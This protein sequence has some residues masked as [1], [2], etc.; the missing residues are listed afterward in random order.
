MGVYRVVA[1]AG[2]VLAVMGCA[3]HHPTVG[4]TENGGV[5]VP[6]RQ[7]VRP[8][9][10]SLTFPGRPVDMALSPDGRRLYVKDNRGIVVIDAAA[11]KVAQELG[12][13][14][15]QGGS[16]HGIAVSADG[17]TVYATTAQDRLC[18]ARVG[19]DGR[20]A[21]TRPVPLPGP[22]GEGLSHATG[23]ALSRD[24]ARAYVC[25]SRNNA[26]AVV[27]L[28]RGEKTAEI[29]VGVAPYDVALSP[30]GRQAWVSNWGGRQ[31]EPGEPTAHSSGTPVV[32]DPRGVAASGTVSLVDLEAGR[33]TAQIEV[34]LHPSD[35]VLSPDGRAL[36]VANANSDTVSVLD[37]AAGAVVGTLN[38]RPEAEL[39]FGSQPNA[40]ALAPDGS[41]LYVANAG[42]NAVAVLGLGAA[43]PAFQGLIPAGWY[44][45]AVVSSGSYLYTASVKGY[46][47]RRRDPLKQGWQVYSH[48]GVVSRVAVPSPQT[49]QAYTAQA[50]RGARVK[51]V[52]A[53]RRAPNPQ[54]RPRPVP[55]R[56]G[57]PS[58]F[59]HVVYIVKENRTYDQ[60][61]GDL[62]QGNGDPELCVFGRRITP[63]HHALAEQFVLL[64]NF[65][66]N[67]VNSADGH[68]WATE[69]NVTDHLEKSFGGF[70]RS[71]TWGDD[72]LTYSASGF[73]W[74]NVLAHGKTFLNFGE[75]DYTE[76]VPA[77]ASFTDILYD[78]RSGRRAIQ[79]THKI[80]IENLARHTHPDALGWNMNIPDVLRADIFVQDL[81]EWE[82]KGD[83]PDFLMLFLPQD[84]GSGTKPGVP[85]HRAHM[86]DNDLALGRVVEAITKSRFWPE[87]CIFVIEDDPQD[88]FD[89]VDGHRSL[90]LVISPYTR[91]GAVVSEFYNQTSV[92]HT[93][94]RILGL[95]PMNQMDAMAPLMEACFQ[96]KPDLTPYAALPANI[97]LDELNPPLSALRGEALHWARKSLE[98]DLEG[99][100]RV[101][102]DTMN[103]IIWH[104]AKG[105]DKPYPA[106][107]AG[108]HGTGLKALGLRLAREGEAE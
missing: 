8:A 34:G 28:A 90:C 27:D 40:L 89:H 63:N 70:T 102:D 6:T 97:P 95:P 18:V 58:V 51:E 35:L 33:E 48:L 59:K 2:A 42:N 85:T 73:I 68:S 17:Q 12:F 101:D 30:D 4:S 65:Y 11:W 64:D 79:F 21:W 96:R 26:L 92:L 23:I 24:G 53:A 74:D 44:P 38:A 55:R 108:A 9:G 57:E 3:V 75:M 20:L 66:C 103:R 84:H 106:H 86:A 45:G 31:A 41:R 47:S 82:K 56:P 87:T 93:M 80:G 94:A 81:R 10:Q 98:Q 71:Y 76:P 16:M 22:G 25:L 50:L 105:S 37:T 100:D 54:A 19:D 43:A 1:A 99:M 7:V 83:W 69:G 60:V 52:L 15:G 29:P 13:G 39:P 72:P 91:R 61:F 104:A 107:L 5:L 67:G 88:G 62:P 36:Y 14:E 77:D 32:I 49:L 46:G 78:F